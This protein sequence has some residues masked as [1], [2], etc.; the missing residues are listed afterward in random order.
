MKKLLLLVLVMFALNA[1]SQSLKDLLFSGKMKTDSGTV[2]RKGEDLKDKVDTATKKPAPVASEK[3]KPA[4]IN[5][6]SVK[7]ASVPVAAQAPANTEAVKPAEEAAPASPQA[8]ATRDN[9]RIW[10]EFVD[11]VLGSIKA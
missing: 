4:S 8:T 6:D 5:T 7:T 11:T 10:K 1:Q 2:V 9:N 3:A